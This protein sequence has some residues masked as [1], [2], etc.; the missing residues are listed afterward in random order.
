MRFP[1]L[2]VGEHTRFCTNSSPGPVRSPRT[3]EWKPSDPHNDC[4]KQYRWVVI[5]KEGVE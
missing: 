1:N 5:P 2:E 3:I 4:L